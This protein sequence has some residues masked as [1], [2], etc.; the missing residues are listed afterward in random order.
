MP[1]HMSFETATETKD[2]LFNWPDYFPQYVPT[3]GE[4]IKKS[5]QV[6]QAKVSGVVKFADWLQSNFPEVFA[7]VNQTRPEIFMPEF[8]MSGLGGLGDIATPDTTT[9]DTSWGKTIS[10]LIAPLIGVYTQ[11]KLIDINIKRAEQGLAPLTDTSAF[12]PTVNVD[13]SPALMAPIQQMGSM[14]AIG[15]VGLGVLFFISR[16]KR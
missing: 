13:A 11:K 1:L 3:T 6:A 4:V 9:P 2:P 12:N 14:L 5:A 8:A 15:L 7:A 10:D 16:R